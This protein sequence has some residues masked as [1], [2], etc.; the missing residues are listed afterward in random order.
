MSFYSFE[1]FLH[2]AAICVYAISIAMILVISERKIIKL[3]KEN[4]LFFLIAVVGLVISVM[5]FVIDYYSIVTGARG[6]CALIRVCDVWFDMGLSFLWMT[7]VKDKL[8]ANVNKYIYRGTTVMFGILL[9]LTF[10]SYGVFMNDYYFV[11]SR[12]LAIKAAVIETAVMIFF[13]IIN[14][15][16]IIKI[17]RLMFPDMK[18]KKI[19]VLS[20]VG[21]ILMFLDCTQSGIIGIKLIFGNLTLYDYGETTS[22][23]PTARL[24]FA[25]VIMCYIVK[26]FFLVKYQNKSKTAMQ[27]EKLIDGE[28]LVDVIA[29]EAKLTKQETIIAKLLYR[30]STYKGIAEELFISVNTVKHH[31]TSIYSKLGVTSK[32]ELIELV[33]KKA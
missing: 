17:A 20:L 7:F 28:S 26:Y 10:I 11:E 2:I 5:Y 9:V 12:Q 33:N 8:F 23:S 29:A 22:I 13:D 6:C 16:C 1:G 14:I 31:I 27:Q 24:I 18:D 4:I 3:T 32:M 25:V 21:C 30:G 19:K 15:V